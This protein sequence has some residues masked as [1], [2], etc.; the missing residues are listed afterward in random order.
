MR[1]LAQ[2][3]VRLLTLT[4]PP[5]IGKTRLAVELA[6]RA[7]EAFPDG[8]V[9]VDLAPLREA[10]QVPGAIAQALRIRQIP[11]VEPL[12]SLIDHLQGRAA[13][14]VLDNFEQ[15]VDASPQVAELL[16][17]C[18]SL[19]CLVTS[20][21]ALRLAWEQ[22]F[23]VPPLAAPDP[24]RL[25]EGA[26]DPAE[27]RRVPSVA[28]F[29]ERARAVAPAFDLTAGNA[30]AVAEICVRLD[31]MPLAIELAAARA[32][33]LAPHQIAA[34]L[35]DRFA[36][37]TRG[38]PSAHARHRTLRGVMDWSYDLLAPEER[39]VL[40]RLGVF[41]GP[42]TLAA[43][44]EVVAGPPVAA[45]RAL[46]MIATLVEHS[47][48]VA[49]TA[50]P[51]P[52]RLLETIREYALARLEEAGETAAARDRHLTYY[53]RLSEEGAHGLEGPRDSGLALE[54]AAQHENIRAAMAWAQARGDEAQGLRLAIAAAGRIW[55]GRIHPAEARA[56]LEGWLP[57][58]EASPELRARGLYWA[59]ELAWEVG[60]TPRAVAA[61]QESVALFR[62]LHHRAGIAAALNTLAV[63]LYRKGEYAPARAAVDESLGIARALGDAGAT[64]FALL[65]RG[66]IARLQ[67]DYVAAE[68][69]GRESLAVARDGGLLRAA[70]LALDSLGLLAVQRGD[71][72]SGERL[73]R[74]ALA[75][76]R[77]LDD[78]YGVAA[79]LNTLAMA[80]LA[81]GDVA[82]ARARSLESLPISQRVAASGSV[83]RSRLTRARAA[84]L[85][86]DLP[87]ALAQAGE[88]L[89]AFRTAGEPLGVIQTIET[90]G[91]LAVRSGHAP[92]A[93]RLMACAAS[94]RETLG[95]EAPPAER[96]AVADAMR[97]AAAAPD[98]APVAQS[99]GGAMTLEEAVQA[100]EAF[101]RTRAHPVPAAALLGRRVTVRLLGGFEAIRGGR[102]LPRQ[103]W[104]RRRDRVLFCFLLV[105]R[106]PVPREAVLDA[107]WPDLP[108]ASARASLNVAWSNIKRALQADGDPAVD[109]LLLDR[110]RYGVRR[111]LVQT[112]VEE[113]ERHLAAADRLARRQGAGDPRA[114]AGGADADAAAE[115]EAAVALYRGDLLPDLA[116]EPWTTVERERLRAAFIAALER[117]AAIR[118]GQG[119][120]AEAEA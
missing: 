95:A 90:L 71:P 29:V 116:N 38:S 2:P 108:P 46:E 61:L 100:A 28:L 40:R 10:A 17:T 21:V 20:R 104:R 62:R 106:E 58:A 27:L 4:G 84:L 50:A 74:E 6:R 15:V 31:G 44:A 77:K 59:G 65:V 112:D 3:G 63:V 80:S 86:G 51:A 60:D 102:V 70:A 12:D 47:L 87:E 26:V 25:R 22:Q 92:T 109:Y 36:L 24:V 113:F 23:P 14:L 49:D 101:L 82:Q 99:S 110:G 11:G 98:A 91:V 66:I 57:R 89:H 55:A 33:V 18:G 79:T 103:V 45:G 107:L 16:A 35:G 41:A 37:L 93:L 32:A 73:S 43:A 69:F 42:F 56:W 34:R 81:R 75:I 5:G 115:L 8:V 105:A 83:G 120:I 67:G 30:A 78:A 114:E 1:L 19:K 119:R 111:D 54:V 97:Q 9:F 53:L 64:A 118:A 94:A 85:A 48:V 117:L 72:D 68:R 52:Y 76:F 88:A 7:A 39:A 96:E 13:L